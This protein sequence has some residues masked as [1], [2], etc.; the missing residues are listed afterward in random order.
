MTEQDQLKSIESETRDFLEKQAMDWGHQNAALVV[1]LNAIT[2][3]CDEL[4]ETITACEKEVSEVYRALTNNRFSKMNTQAVYILDD[5]ERRATGGW[6]SQ[7]IGYILTIR[8]TNTCEW[9]ELLA[10][11]I[12]EIAE[13]I[14][15]EDR[16][17]FNGDGLTVKKRRE[18]PS[19][20]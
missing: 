15:D 2:A 5:I 20:D 11:H 19:T 13:H 9:M 6:L 12:N 18:Q 7:L 4:Q 1:K 3:E 14:G 8:S 17:E 10:A 16:V